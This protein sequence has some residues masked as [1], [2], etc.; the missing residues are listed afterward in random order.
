M[1]EKRRPFSVTLLLV[2]VLLVA[3]WGATRFTAAL[4]WR[5][6]L[7]EFDS[8]L[9]VLYLSATGAGWGAAGGALALGILRRKRWAAAGSFAVI[10]L[11]V[12]EYWIERLFFETS[13]ANLP[14]ALTVS[15]LFI[16]G[17]LANLPQTRSYFTK[18]EAHEQPVEKPDIA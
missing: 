13:R 8:S 10:V 18:S 11:W 6:V 1:P 7:T 14:F 12:S 16:A 3:V 4:R 2:M 15:A 5:N 9:S 17:L